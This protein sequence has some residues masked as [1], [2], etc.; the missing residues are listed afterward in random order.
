MFGLSFQQATCFSFS[1]FIMGRSFSSKD[2]G[3]VPLW[4][5]VVAFL[6]LSLTVWFIRN[7]GPSPEVNDEIS[8]RKTQQ[9][10]IVS[11]KEEAPVTSSSRNSSEREEVAALGWKL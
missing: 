3:R 5:V 6:Q 10:Q 2:R 9:I 4:L 1:D 8:S 11:K 7:L